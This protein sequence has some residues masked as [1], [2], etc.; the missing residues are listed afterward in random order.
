M[1]VFI[2][3]TYVVINALYFLRKEDGNK[4]IIAMA[5]LTAIPLFTDDYWH[6]L[7]LSAALSVAIL[8]VE[9]SKA[10]PTG[11]GAIVALFAFFLVA[12][13]ISIIIKTVWTF[14]TD[15]SFSTFHLDGP[16]SYEWPTYVIALYGLAII[17]ALTA[18]FR[19]NKE[20]LELQNINIAALGF[21]ALPHFCGSFLYGMALS[22][23][24]VA[25]LFLLAIIRK[26]DSEQRFL[27][28]YSTLGIIPGSFLV[29]G[30]MVAFF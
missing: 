7:Q 14:F 16:L 9:G 5:G 12:F 2:I 8:V 29:K 3:L 28:A 22:L 24:I 17:L 30:I 11:G 26:I 6:W 19:S 27:F 4:L 25:I 1:F 10:G 15:F 18:I 20:T 13:F 21:A 23:S